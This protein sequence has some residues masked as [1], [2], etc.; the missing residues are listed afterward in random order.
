MK[1]G[2]GSSQEITDKV[3]PGTQDPD[4]GFW[5][6]AHSLFDSFCCSNAEEKT[7]SFP[8][9]DML[10]WLRLM[11]RQH[12]LQTQWNT[13]CF[14]SCCAHCFAL[15]W[16]WA[17]SLTTWKFK[18]FPVFCLC[19]TWQ[20]RN[21]QSIKTQSPGKDEKY[22]SQKFS[23]GLS[24]ISLSQRAQQDQKMH[25]RKPTQVFPYFWEIVSCHCLW[26]AQ[27]H[28][29]GAFCT[30]CFLQHTWITVIIYFCTVN[31]SIVLQK[32]CQEQSTIGLIRAKQ[33]QKQ[34]PINLM[35]TQAGKLM[36][37]TSPMEKFAWKKQ[38]PKN[39]LR[40]SF[41]TAEDW[42]LSAFLVSL[43]ALSPQHFGGLE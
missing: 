17:W 10:C 8:L 34:C 35:Q 13:K 32:S 5:A 24:N 28:S 31:D 43:G 26:F 42:V 30:T 36:R 33:K 27:T 41:D 7:R 12:F 9:Q 21:W 23:H 6:T 38:K 3:A 11:S 40:T 20:K 18:F 22:W 14:A 16:L 19:N 37:M 15:T 4:K 39:G 25:S 1:D 29:S 2:Q